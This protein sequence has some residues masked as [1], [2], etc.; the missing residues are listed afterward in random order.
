VDWGQVFSDGVRT[1][2]GPQ[3]IAYA[4]AA[5]GLNVHFGYT[6]LLN[7]GH[8]GFMLVGAY[9][10]AITAGTYGWPLPLAFLVGVLAACALGLVLGLPTLRLRAEYL[11]IVTISVAEILRISVSSRSFEGVTGGT[12]GIRGWAGWF[13]DLNPYDSGINPFGQVSFNARQLWV[14]TVG[15]ALV[16]LASLFVAALVR[17][18]WG[19]VLRAIREDEDAARSLGKNVF[20]FKLQSLVVGGSIGGLAG[21]VLAVDAAYADPNLWMSTVTFVAYTVLILGGPGRVLGPVLG[22]ITFW[23]LLQSVDR[24][25]RQAITENSWAGQYI[26]TTQVGQ[27]RFALVGLGLMLLMIFRPQ[28]MIGNKREAALGGR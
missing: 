22:S 6:G 4:L 13:F 16:V 8:V 15:W 23:F 3:A 2:L 20:G 25:L 21:I 18:P 9:G 24:V 26:E 12:Q 5:I 17:S 28:G 11:A 14:I 7:F 1:A 10:T 19:R 27:I